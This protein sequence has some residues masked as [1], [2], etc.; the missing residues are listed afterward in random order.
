MEERSRGAIWRSSSGLTAG[1]ATLNMPVLVRHQ[2]RCRHHK[3][4]RKI[5][6]GCDVDDTWKFYDCA[7]DDEYKSPSVRP[8]SCLVFPVSSPLYNEVRRSRISC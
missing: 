2:P 5:C 8:L 3:S 6:G 4:P 1:A 7:E